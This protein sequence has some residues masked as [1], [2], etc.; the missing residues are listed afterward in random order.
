[1]KLL[2]DTNILID[3][4]T[5]R[6][7]FYDHAQKLCIASYFGDV[8]LWANV[9]SYLDASYALRKMTSERAL[10]DAMLGTLEFIHPCGNRAADLREALESDWPDVEDF[11]IAKGAQNVAADYVV[12]RDA[13]GFF[14]S[15]IRAISSKDAMELLASKGMFY[16]EVII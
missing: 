12:T 15:K 1:M 8:E 6:A 3:L 13:K 11:L 2:I 16:D 14:D 7:P 9:Q 4:L 5:K 10:R